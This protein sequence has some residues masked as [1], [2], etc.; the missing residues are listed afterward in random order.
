MR[1]LVIEDD[2]ELADAIAAGLRMEGMAVDTAP[3][4]AAGLDRALVND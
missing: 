1:V 4:G 3:D 2:G